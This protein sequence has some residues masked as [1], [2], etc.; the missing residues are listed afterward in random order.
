ME[1]NRLDYSLSEEAFAQNSDSLLSIALEKLQYRASETA[2][3]LDK[4]SASLI[5]ITID[6]D[7]NA[8][9]FP[10]RMAMM[11]SGQDNPPMATP[12]AIPGQS[13]V[14]LNVSAKALL[15]P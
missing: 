9:V 5:E 7:R 4:S 2:E 3:L 15:S 6:G 8:G 10:P 1:I 14:S 13:E 11:E 12:S